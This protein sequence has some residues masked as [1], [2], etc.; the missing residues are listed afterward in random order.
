MAK[1]VTIRQLAKLIGLYISTFPASNHAALHYRH[2]ERL[3]VR[4]LKINNDKWDRK[5]SIDSLGKK[6]NKMV[7]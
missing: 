6:E 2:L 3:K 7:V 1:H 5:I 4:Q